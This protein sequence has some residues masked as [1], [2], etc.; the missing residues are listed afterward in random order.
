MRLP[1]IRNVLCSTHTKGFRNLLHKALKPHSDP[2]VRDHLALSE[3]RSWC[4]H[5]A[6][7]LTLPGKPEQGAG[8]SLPTPI[9]RWHL[10]EILICSSPFPSWSTQPGQDQVCRWSRELPVPQHSKESTTIHH[11]ETGQ[12]LITKVKLPLAVSARSELQT[13]IVSGTQSFAPCPD[14]SHEFGELF[15][16]IC[17]GICCLISGRTKRLHQENEQQ[18][19]TLPRVLGSS[20]RFDRSP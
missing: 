13:H 2:Q 16:G 14:R 1:T 6:P 7:P 12:E 8:S 18:A 17:C 11:P 5:G 3:P 4:V 20:T 9:Q 10:C 15:C 19:E